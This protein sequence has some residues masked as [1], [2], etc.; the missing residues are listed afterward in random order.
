MAIRKH[1]SLQMLVSA[2]ASRHGWKAKVTN[3]SASPWDDDGTGFVVLEYNGA[4]VSF[5]YGLP[6]DENDI[7]HQVRAIVKADKLERDRRA[8]GGDGS[9]VTRMGE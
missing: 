5:E 9:P 3:N 2:E 1:G 6:E 7:A 4:S 8:R